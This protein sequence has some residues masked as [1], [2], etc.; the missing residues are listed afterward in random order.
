MGREL[1]SRATAQRNGTNGNG[2]NGEQDEVAKTLGGQIQRMLPEY[3][4]AMPK[5][6]EATQLIRDALTCLRTIPKLD[7]CE[8]ASVL[9]S[10]MT[11]AQLDLRPGVAGL[12]HAWP[13]PFWDGKTQGLKAQLVIGY[14][15]YI[16]LGFRSGKLAGIASRIVYENETDDFE[17]IYREDGDILTHKPS[18]R[19]LRGGIVCFYSTARI[20]GGGYGLTEPVSL[21]EMEAHRDKYA[22]RDKFKK[23]TGPWVNHFAAMGKKTMILRNFA[24]LPKSAE[25]SIAMEA[26]NGVRVDLTP[27][28]SAAEVTDHPARLLAGQVEHEDSQSGEESRPS[29]TLTAPAARPAPARRSAETAA[30]ADAAPPA[31]S[32]DPGSATE[33]QV[34]KLASLYQNQLGFKRAEHGLTVGASEQI[35]GRDLTGPHDGQSHANLSA[36]EA[37]KL[38]DTLD[39]ITDR[40]RLVEYLTTPAAGGGTDD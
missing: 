3:Q 22:P 11:C 15:G 13:L 16:E 8:P 35:I 27:T 24:N 39:S 28:A 32:T 36:A 18:Y 6:R 5:G 25:M 40:D 10:L 37:R 30:A 23:M 20:I 1:A 33:A 19:G 17:F 9:G 38:I 4:A 14:K 7:Q 21:E 29:I 31:S 26:D 12:G 2:Q 34:G